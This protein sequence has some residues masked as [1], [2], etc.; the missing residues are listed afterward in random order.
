MLVVND[1]VLDHLVNIHLITY[2]DPTNT[3]IRPH[4]CNNLKQMQFY[5]KQTIEDQIYPKRYIAVTMPAIT[6]LITSN[7]RIMLFQLCVSSYSR[8]YLLK[9]VH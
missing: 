8:S 4:I 1:L 9:N 3:V 6:K 7:D 2:D 5:D